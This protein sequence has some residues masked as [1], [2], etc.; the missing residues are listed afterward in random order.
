MG[1]RRYDPR[2][3]HKKP[4]GA[5][6]AGGEHPGPGGY[7]PVRPNGRHGRLY[8]G[9]EDED[10]R[11]ARSPFGRLGALR[12]IEDLSSFG[13]AILPKNSTGSGILKYFVW[14]CPGCGY[15]N[16]TDLSGTDPV[17]LT[18]ARCR[19]SIGEDT[20]ENLERQSPP[21]PPDPPKRR[22]PS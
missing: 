8:E 13:G 12:M 22:S 17:E 2:N 18:C 6:F 1:H 9:D 15:R 4:Q 11:P 16:T 14:D 19:R 21:H 5:R 20:P 10:H 3:S 7:M